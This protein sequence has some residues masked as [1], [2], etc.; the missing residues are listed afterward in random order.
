MTGA[1]NWGAVFASK[2][3]I[4][5]TDVEHRIRY[6]DIIKILNMEIDPSEVI[7]FARVAMQQGVSGKMVNLKPHSNSFLIHRHI[8]LSHGM[9]D[10]R[11]SGHYGYDDKEL[12]SRLRSQ[13][14]VRPEPS[15]SL[16]M[17][18]QHDPQRRNRTVNRLRLQMRALQSSVAPM[19]LVDDAHVVFKANF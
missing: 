18:F 12:F 10:E 6:P 17:R 19:R 13:L 1:A 11:F 2:S 4:L 14:Q 9:Y 3:L 15:I 8:F 5:K 16:E 7:L